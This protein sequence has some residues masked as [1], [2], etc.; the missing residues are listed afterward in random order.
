M[1]ATYKIVYKNQCTPQEKVNFSTGS[2]WYLD[3]DCGR[4]LAGTG[5]VTVDSGRTYT[6]SHAVTDAFVSIASGQDFVYIKNT[7]TDDIIIRINNDSYQL[8]ISTGETFTSKISPSAD[9]KIKCGSGESSTA[10][11]IKGT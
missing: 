5:S 6:A 7:G 2:R 3:S 1:A 8:Q 9:V 11:I 4:Q 10:E